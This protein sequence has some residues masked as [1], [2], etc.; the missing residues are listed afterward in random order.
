VAEDVQPQFRIG[1]VAKLTG[2]SIHRI[3]VWE[4]RYHTVE[5]GR[6]DGG[7]RL[8]SEEDVRRLGLLKQLDDLGY[9]IGSTANLPL[10]QLERM[11]ALHEESP[12]TRPRVVRL[13]PTPSAVQ[14]TAADIAQPFLDAIAQLDV[15]RAE[16]TL[17]RA[18]GTSDPP[19]FAAQVLLPLLEEIGRRWAEGQLSVAHEH[20]ASAVLRT[21]LGAL[22]RSFVPDEDA[23]VALCATP[24]AELHEFG[25]LS[26]AL[27]VAS[28]GWRAV[29]LGPNLPAHEIVQAARVASARLVLLSVVCVAECTF[30]ELEELAKALPA[31]VTLMI[32]G[33]AA[34]S[35]SGLPPRVR[36]AHALGDL[37]PL[38]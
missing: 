34:T 23:P 1:V 17:A 36:R 15:L 19:R 11:L 28:H 21:Q 32:G 4:R 25:A 12:T 9:A 20:A 35:L 2:L 6:S 27:Y 26:A 8:Y 13:A 38:L 7:D 10:A 33:A 24:A 16:R 3:R 5:P 30:A 37:A 14:S 31:E 29:Y 22:M 18:A